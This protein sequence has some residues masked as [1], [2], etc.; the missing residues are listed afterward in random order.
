[1]SGAC[2]FEA[3]EKTG[4]GGVMNQNFHCLGDAI[5]IEKAL[6]KASGG[7]RLKILQRRGSDCVPSR[8]LPTCVTLLSQLFS[9]GLC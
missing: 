9:A 8:K 7:E 4:G 1:M 2:D 3:D 6:R 5:V